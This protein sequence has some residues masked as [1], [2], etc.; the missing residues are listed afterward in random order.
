M[1]LI[2]GGDGLYTVGSMATRHY[3]RTQEEKTLPGRPQHLEFGRHFHLRLEY[4]GIPTNLGSAF[5]SLLSRLHKAQG[6]QGA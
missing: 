2:D 1:F 3:Y 5:P 6:R 4:V